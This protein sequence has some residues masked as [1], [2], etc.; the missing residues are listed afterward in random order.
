MRISAKGFLAVT[1]EEALLAPNL[2]VL[3]AMD[4]AAMRAYKTLG[5]VLRAFGWKVALPLC[6]RVH[7]KRT[8]LF[9]FGKGKSHQVFLV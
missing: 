6:N 9:E 5:E 8:N 2:A 3:Y 4:G 7:D 1:T